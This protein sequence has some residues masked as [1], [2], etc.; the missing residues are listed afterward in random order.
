MIDRIGSSTDVSIGNHTKAGEAWALPGQVGMAFVAFLKRTYR[1]YKPTTGAR[2]T[3][4]IIMAGKPVNTHQ[5][6][7]LDC[8]KV[9]ASST[10]AVRCKPHAEAEAHRLK[11][12]RSKNSYHRQ[13]AAH[14]A[15][16]R[17]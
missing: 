4:R 15:A 7:C 2:K 12:E 11:L 8:G 6:V 1:D 10:R 13:K 17:G 16:L 3:L 5:V 9:F 14:E